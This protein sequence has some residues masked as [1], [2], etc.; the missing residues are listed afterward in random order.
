M[1]KTNLLQAA[2]IVAVLVTVVSGAVA[3]QYAVSEL[4]YKAE[5]AEAAKVCGWLNEAVCD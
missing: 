1:A 2:I 5:A 3:C 4:E